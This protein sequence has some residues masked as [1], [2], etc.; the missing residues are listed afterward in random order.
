MR[1]EGS[2]TLNVGGAIHGLGSQ[3]KERKEDRELSTNLHLSLPLDGRP[4][5]TSYLMSLLVMVCS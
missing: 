5:L 2:P 3:T 4:N 1:V